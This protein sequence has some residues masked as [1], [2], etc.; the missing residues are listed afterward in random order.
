MWVFRMSM[1]SDS[2]ECDWH[3]GLLHRRGVA[4]IFDFKGS[5]FQNLPDGFG[6]GNVVSNST[7]AKVA[8]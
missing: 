5:V 6:A 8:R 3:A 4:F 2:G 7:A 1:T